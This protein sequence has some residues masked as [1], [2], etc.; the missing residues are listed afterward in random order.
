MPTRHTCVRNP[1]LSTAVIEK[2][3]EPSLSAYLHACGSAQQDASYASQS[4]CHTQSST[5]HTGMH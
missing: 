3:Y 1:A 4:F 2:R 5:W